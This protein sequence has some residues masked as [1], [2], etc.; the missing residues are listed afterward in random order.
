MA[1]EEQGV[2]MIIVSR[3]DRTAGES[4]VPPSIFHLHLSQ[5]IERII[6]FAS[7][8]WN[9]GAAHGHNAGVTLP[10]SPI[11]DTRVPPRPAS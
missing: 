6:D 1:Q 10:V 4:F 3:K 2:Q 5:R 8:H 11:A 7:S 9:H